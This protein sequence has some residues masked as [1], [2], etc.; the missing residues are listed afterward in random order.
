MAVAA[1]K[2]GTGADPVREARVDLAAAHRL[3]RHFGYDSGIFNHFTLTVPGAT[4]RFLVKAHGL[5][6]SEISAS[7]LIVVDS[8]GAVVEGEGIVEASAFCIHS[9]IHELH[10]SAHCVLHAHP[11]YCTWLADVKGGVVEMVDQDSVRFYDRIAYDED[12]GGVAFDL[13][14]GERIA[15]TMG[16]KPILISRSHG[17]TVTGASVSQAFDDLFYLEQ[18]CAR[19]FRVYASGR[20]AEM[21]PQAVLES[22]G[23][24]YDDN[25]RAE[26]A[27]L[28]F[29]ALKRMLDSEMPGYDD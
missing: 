15:R 20:E 26:A 11:P 13:D 9:K 29:D 3:A 5:L 25:Y 10:P 17:V 7:N 6:M 4:G 27:R 19:Q 28:Y 23:D 12:Y 24:G 22:L 14:E 16:D 1:R 21:I 8:E 18:A 2:I